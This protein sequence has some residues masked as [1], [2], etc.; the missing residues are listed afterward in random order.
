[1]KKVF[2]C[3]MIVL[4]VITIIATMYVSQYNTNISRV[5]ENNQEYE[6]YLDKEVFGTVVTTIINKATNQNEK[7]E[8]DKDEK[9]Y[10]IENDTNSIKVELIMLNGE[11]K[12]TYQMENIQKAGINGFIKNFNLIEF[13]CSKIEYHQKTNFISKIV[14]EQLEE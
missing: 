1:M 14:F 2:I 11:E 12:V 13:K 6:Q 10:Y 9:G 7:N 5:K 4:V 8:I 3:L